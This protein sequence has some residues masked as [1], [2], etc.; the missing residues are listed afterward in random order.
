MYT[1]QFNL[2]LFVWIPTLEQEL[3]DHVS[4]WIKILRQ[5][6]S[7]AP[8]SEANQ[9][10]SHEVCILL[11]VFLRLESLLSAK[12]SLCSYQTFEPVADV[13]HQTLLA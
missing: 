1:I 4:V 3:G 8:R 7:R 10:L 13:L 9:A 6:T 2:V 12:T 5:H 11:R